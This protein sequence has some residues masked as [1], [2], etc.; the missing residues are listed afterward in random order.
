M[1][2]RLKANKID[3]IHFFIF[4]KYIFLTI[5]KFKFKKIYAVLQL[6]LR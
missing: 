3:E 5:L 6:I 1:C 4:L 2:Y